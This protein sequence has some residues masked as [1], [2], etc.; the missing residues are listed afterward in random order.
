M[1]NN[2]PNMHATA[3]RIEAHGL[4]LIGPSGS[5]KSRLALE[6]L[7]LARF[8]GS[9][10]ALIGDD[11]VLIETGADFAIAHAAE[12]I[13]GLIEARFSGI[14]KLKTESAVQ[15]T[16]A[17]LPVLPGPQSERLPDMAEHF[18]LGA[19]VKLPLIRLLP[20]HIANLTILE[21]LLQQRQFAQ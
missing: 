7:E 4:L 13:S 19:G 21:N 15:L 17:I 6:L 20:G 8:R 1:K 5:G 12:T 2:W 18:T 14:L 16:A 9:D 11:Q 10:H 3:I